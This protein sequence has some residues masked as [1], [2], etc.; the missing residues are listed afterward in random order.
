MR[1]TLVR[2]DKELQALTHEVDTLKET[3]QRLESEILTLMEG[4]DARTARIK[5]LTE[6]IAMGRVELIAAEKEIAA[7]LRSRWPRAGPAR[8]AACGCR[9]SSTTRSR[10][11]S[12][13][14][15][16]RTASASCTTRSGQ[17]NP[18]R[19]RRA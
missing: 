16:A 9:R 4:A 8:D 2:N 5:E 13:F 19:S 10:S 14:T 1:L 12:R 18:I 11:I 17:K 6:A 3:N 7:E 15:S